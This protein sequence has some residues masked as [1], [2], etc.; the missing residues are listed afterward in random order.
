[1]RQKPPYTVHTDPRNA[2]VTGDAVLVI[3]PGRVSF[4]G[5]AGDLDPQA[6]ADAWALAGAL[7]NSGEAQAVPDVPTAV[8]ILREER[9]E[10]REIVGRQAALIDKLQ[11]QRRDMRA[12]LRMTLGLLEK[13]VPDA[14][15]Q[16]S[17]HAGQI[18][19]AC[20]GDEGDE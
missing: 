2:I 20:R 17:D 3:G 1:M 19:A 8:E 10:L 7:R 11:Q 9:D 5:R 16:L 15:W 6:I 14:E 12:A 13:Y 4:H 18:Y